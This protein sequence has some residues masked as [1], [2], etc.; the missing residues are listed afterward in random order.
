MD[1]PVRT[2]TTGGAGGGSPGLTEVRVAVR[3]SPGKGRGVFALAPI[4][5]GST[6]EVA[7][8]L[9]F[10]AASYEQHGRHTLLDE[11]V[12]KWKGGAWALA[13]GIGSLFNHH[14]TPNCGWMADFSRHELRFVALTD[15]EAGAELTVSYGSR[16]WFEDSTREADEDEEGFHLASASDLLA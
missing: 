13:L 12:F 2:L 3:D 10:D 11:Y 4:T 6:V 16:V 8:V 14:S 7:P 1:P 9:L 5:R 15:V